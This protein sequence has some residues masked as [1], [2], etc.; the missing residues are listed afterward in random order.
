MSLESFLRQF[1]ICTGEFARAVCFSAASIADLE[2]AAAL[3]GEGMRDPRYQAYLHGGDWI[4]LYSDLPA[5]TTSRVRFSNRAD[6]AQARQR[7]GLPDRWCSEAAAVPRAQLHSRLAAAHDPRLVLFL[8]G[9]LRGMGLP[10]FPHSDPGHP[11]PQDLDYLIDGDDWCQTFVA[12][13]RDYGWWGLAYR[14]SV[15]R[16]AEH[17]TRRRLT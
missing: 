11:G 2:L 10:L 8:I 12:L 14:Q 1:E 16:S 3:S 7:V 6:A 5:I 4:A 15:L 17:V 9:T 13:R